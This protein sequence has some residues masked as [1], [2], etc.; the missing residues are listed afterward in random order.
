MADFLRPR[1]SFWTAR[2]ASRQQTA[3]MQLIAAISRKGTSTPRAM[4]PKGS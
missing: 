4:R 2:A 3:A 1:A